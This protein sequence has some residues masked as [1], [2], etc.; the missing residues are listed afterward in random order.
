EAAAGHRMTSVGFALGTPAYM[1]PEQAAADPD[2][3]HRADLY[4]L[5]IVAYEM[6]T[7]RLPYAATTPPQLLAAHITQPP[8]PITT[9]RPDLPPELAAAVMR[10]LAKERSARWPTADALRDALERLGPSGASTPISGTQ[11]VP[12]MP[13]TETHPVQV[14]LL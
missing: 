5:G 13:R 12:A 3:D 10:C 2:V 11:P 7:G 4:A 6:L 14:G 9:V 8:E 1:A